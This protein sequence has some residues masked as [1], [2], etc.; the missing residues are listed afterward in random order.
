M[1]LDLTRARARR[2]AAALAVAA[3]AVCWLVGGF[4]SPHAAAAEIDGAITNVTLTPPAAGPGDPIRVDVDWAVPDS[5]GAGD[6]FTLTL[7]PQLTSLTTSFDLTAP[8]GAV[9]AHA[10][11]VNGVVTF[12]LTDY[13]DTHNGLHGDAFFSVKWNT[14]TTTTTGPISLDFGTTTTVFHRTEIKNPAVG[15]I[16]RTEPRKTGHWVTPGV[17]NGPDALEWVIDSPNGPFDKATFDDT[18]GPGQAID[19][20]TLE[21]QLG[22]GLDANGQASQFRPLQAS[23][24]ISSTCSATSLTAATGPILADQIVRIRYAV[25][26]TDPTLPVY[27]NAVH[28]T[29]DST[30]YGTVT[31][32]VKVT[33]AGGGGSGTRSPTSTTSSTTTTST[34]TSTSSATT[35]STSSTTDSTPTTSSTGPTTTTATTSPTSPISSSTV[36]PTKLTSTS[37]PGSIGGLPFTGANVGPMVVAAAIL[38]SGGLVLAL[39]GRRPSDGGR[40]RH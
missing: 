1:V 11:V 15:T 20:S 34:T 36:L 5:A 13:A 33:Q 10:T 37:G 6:T 40:R 12:T 22:S 19:C 30:D 18:P 35:S 24:V 3:F 7:P 14:T 23:K 26:I 16:D 39:A 27:T 21:F 4:L 2:T 38:V 32:R 8:G 28:V 29:V 17:T 31:D 25:D 9:L